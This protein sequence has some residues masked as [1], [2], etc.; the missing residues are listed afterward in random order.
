[1][2]SSFPTTA[3]F[4]GEQALTDSSIHVS[5]TYD[6]LV[7]QSILDLVKS[8]SAGAIVLFAARS[9]KSAHNLVAIAITHRLGVV[10]IGEESVL[11]AVSSP[12]R[13]A[14]WLAGE[15][16]LEKVKERVEIW[17]EEWFEDGGVWRANRD[18]AAGVKVADTQER[19]SEE[20]AG[21]CAMKQGAD[22]DGDGIKSDGTKT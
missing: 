5:L 9:I 6:P 7:S 10:P 21:E 4:A 19:T 22:P 13:K 15:D 3:R 8:P 18:G 14:A 11:V 1:M 16:C 2:A 20:V 12:H 17:K